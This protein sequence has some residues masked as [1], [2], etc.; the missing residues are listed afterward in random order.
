M[1]RLTNIEKRRLIE[2]IQAAYAIPFI[3]DITDFIWE[4]M[5]SYVRDIPIV[6]PLQNTRKKLLYD[7]VDQSSGIGWSAKAIQKSLNLP[8]AFEIVIQR[9]DIF[10]KSADLGFEPLTIDSSPQILGKA[11]LKHW[12]KKVQGDADEQGVTQKRICILLKSLDR[13][14]YSYFEENITEY[15][16]EDLQWQWTDNTRTGLQGVRKKDDFVV[17]RW[18]PNP[19]QLFE[20]FHLSGDAFTFSLE[21]RRL[22]PDELV[23]LLL[24]RLNRR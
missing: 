10:K 22:P 7:V 24:A 18:Y 8:T 13:T 15:S 5:F 23:H 6:D 1:Y 19:K 9:A 3:H 21:P 20:R 2:S 12:Y 4:A 16:A 14:K 17:F 11:L